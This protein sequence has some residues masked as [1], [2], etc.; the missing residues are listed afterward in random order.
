MTNIKIVS[1]KT[2]L[3]NLF[4]KVEALPEDFELQSH[5]AKYLCVLVSGF[6]ETSVR[7]IYSQYAHKRAAP[8]VANY[9]TRRLDSFQNPNMTKIINLTNSFNPGWGDSLREKTEGELKNAIDSICANRNLIA[10]GRDSGITYARIN[11]WYQD[12]IEVVELIEKQCE[13]G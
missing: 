11:D 4:K 6:L 12:A 9:V 10:H 1:Y 7:A 3:D 2:R 5:W 13:D 8:N